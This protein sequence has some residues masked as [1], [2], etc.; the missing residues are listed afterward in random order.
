[1]EGAVSSEVTEDDSMKRAPP[2]DTEVQEVNEH[3][4]SPAGPMMSDEE[5]PRVA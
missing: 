5:A 4:L 3:T 1:M 2:F